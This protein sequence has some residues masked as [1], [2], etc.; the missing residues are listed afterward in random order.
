LRVASCAWAR[1]SRA[2]L[3]TLVMVMDDTAETLARAYHEQGWVYVPDIFSVRDLARMRSRVEGLVDR[4]ASS[5]DETGLLSFGTH[6]EEPFGRRFMALV[7]DAGPDAAMSRLQEAGSVFGVAEAHGSEVDA[8]ERPIFEM[9]SH[10]R[11][12]DVLE[13]LM[14]S[15]FSYS[16]AG[17]MRARL[18]DGAGHSRSAKPFPFHQD[19]QYFD[20][21]RIP[22]GK[23]ST[24]LGGGSSSAPVIPRGQ[25]ISSEQLHIVTVWVPLVD[26]DASNGALT[27][28]SGSHRWGMLDGQRDADGNMQCHNPDDRQRIELAPR[29]VQPCPAGGAILF[30]NLCFHGSGPNLTDSVRWSLDW[31]YDA[32]ASRA[33]HTPKKTNAKEEEAATQLALRWWRE[34]FDRPGRLDYGPFLVRDRTQGMENPSWSSWIAR[35]YS[36]LREAAGGEEPAAKL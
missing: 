3:A 21:A 13:A 22:G 15:T 12:L 10:A 27:L 31:R 28:I 34:Q 17:I 8:L 7:E 6:S 4:A 16:Y 18:P 24:A 25:A 14:G 19:S 1:L 32:G 26:T 20:S 23:P 35:R 5:L 11:L 33:P 36:R 9:V 29:V 30:N 2:T